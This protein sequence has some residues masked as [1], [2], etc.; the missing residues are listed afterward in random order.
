MVLLRNIILVVMLF[1]SLPAHGQKP[2]FRKISINLGLP[3]TVAYSIVQDHEG[4]LWIATPDGVARFDGRHVTTYTAANSPIDYG[5][6]HIFK[7]SKQRLWFISIFSPPVYYTNGQFYR[8]DTATAQS[9]KK[10]TWIAEDSEGKLLFFTRERWIYHLSEELQAI[11]FV[12]NTS[13]IER[14]EILADGTMFLSNGKLLTRVS[15]DGVLTTLNESI[16]NSENNE[17]WKIDDSMLLGSGKDGLYAYSTASSKRIWTNSNEFSSSPYS[18]FKKNDSIFWIGS[19]EGICEFKFKNSKLF[20]VD[21]ILSGKFVITIKRDV[22]GN[23]WVG[24]YEDG[25]FFLNAADPKIHNPAGIEDNVYHIVF[26]NSSGYLFNSKGDFRKLNDGVV[27]ADLNTFTSSRKMLFRKAYKFDTNAI[28]VRVGNGHQILIKG[29]SLEFLPFDFASWALNCFTRNDGSVYT[30]DIY[31][32]GLCRKVKKFVHGKPVYSRIADYAPNFHKSFCVDYHE[33]VWIGYNEQLISLSWMPNGKYRPDTFVFRNEFITDLNCDRKNRLWVATRGGGVYCLKNKIQVAHYTVN[34]GLCTNNCTSLFIDDSDNVWVCSENGL[35]MIPYAADKKTLP[36]IKFTT[37]NILPDNCVN[38]VNKNGEKMYFGTRS[39]LITMD[40]NKIGLIAN[41][42][43][44][45]YITNV[46]VNGKEAKLRQR[47]TLPYGAS[48]AISFSTI[49]FNLDKDPV[50]HYT[51]NE[52]GNNWST[53]PSNKIQYESLPSGQY[54]FRVYAN[55]WKSQG[56]SID[57]IV[58]PPYWEKWWFI[59]LVVAGIA[60]LVTFI[61]LGIVRY[62]NNKNELRRR[63]IESD[64][65]SLKAQINPHFIFNALNSIQDFVVHQQPRAA[66]HYLT[67]FAGLIRMIVDN[68][69]KESLNLG[70]EIRFLNLYLQLE[71]LRLGNSFSFEIICA[72]EIEPSLITIPSMLIQPIAEN[73]IVHGLP[74]KQG[75]KI[76]RIKFEI[77]QGLLCCT[78]SDNGIGL[79]NSKKH[80]FRGP[81]QSMGIGNITERLQLVYKRENLNWIPIDFAEINSGDQY[82]GTIVTFYVPLLKII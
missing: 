21:R 8:L 43:A 23:I 29:N 45:T 18:F 51:I 33:V 65:K 49:S 32:K 11:A 56:A 37:A 72:S 69:Q 52:A 55:S 10:T 19:K 16:N 76:L 36:T 68:A 28:L 50:F 20:F 14:G 53:I 31:K 17:I 63:M 78:I 24:T 47:Y 70:D 35:T 2:F 80:R 48:L 81:K 58:L 38:C 62:K 1:C 9:L 74:L 6:Y 79:E 73:A 34:S 77:I 64:L 26:T 39:G 30:I 67:Q 54:T 27:N 3:G 71:K 57:I 41:Q 25:I 82:P 59:W 44:P 61:I 22:A 60:I 4:F 46:T 13:G 12:K 5:V 7:D 75:E 40:C 15:K 66:N 42:P